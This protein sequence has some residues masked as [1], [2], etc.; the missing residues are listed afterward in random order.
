[1]KYLMLLILA[2]CA[3]NQPANQVKSPLFS[4]GDCI[5]EYNP[6]AE[7]WESTW[8]KYVMKIEKV[9][10]KSYHTSTFYDVG[11]TKFYGGSLDT[12]TFFMQDLY[13]KVD[14]SKVSF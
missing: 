10:K 11:K 12:V 1:M 3:Q 9:G 7:E 8:G 14:C 13:V 2:G 5:Q 6:K 4:V